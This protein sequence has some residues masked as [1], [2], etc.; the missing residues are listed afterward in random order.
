MPEPQIYPGVPAGVSLRDPTDYDALRESIHAR[1]RDAY[2]KRFP[3]ENDRVRLELLGADYDSKKTAF[4]IHDAKRALLEDG[5]LRAPLRGTFRLTDKATGQTLDE[6]KLTFANVPTPSHRGTFIVNG[7]EYAPIQQ[8]RLK[9]G[10]YARRKDNGELE[11]HLNVLSGTG[12][13]MRI[14]MEPDTGVYRLNI[15]QSQNKLY[16]IAKALGI[17]DEEMQAAWGPEILKANQ[18]ASRTSGSRT[19][20]KFYEK[21]LRH[22]ADPAADAGQQSASIAEAVGKMEFDPEVTQR[23]LGF[24][25]ARLTNRALLDA[26]RKL[27][28]VHRGEA[29]GDDRDSLANKTFHSTDDFLEERVRKD[30]GR[31]GNALLWKAGYNRNLDGLRPGYFTPQL[32][33]LIVGNS[34]S[35]AI[36]GINAME[37]RDANFRLTSMGEGGLGS[38]DS[39]PASSRNVSPTHYG[40]IDPIRSSESR[41]IGIDLRLAR[42]IKKGS[43]NQIYAP[44]K[45]RKTGRVEWLNPSQLAGKSLAFSDA[46]TLAPHVTPMPPVITSVPTPVPTHG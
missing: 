3:I 32:Q 28:S 27:L 42:K 40:F 12:P 23:T 30:A 24:P 19:L 1:V 38:M 18:E 44:F 14:H 9:A 11:S 21:L 5:S 10:I 13:Q 31:L 39:V 37:L 8:Q 7:V 43:D 15:Q 46:D 29:E 6:K 20:G 26:S 36:P 25:H 35:G 22:K 2:L 41:A 17:Q 34:L 45:N 4:G 33:E 16:P